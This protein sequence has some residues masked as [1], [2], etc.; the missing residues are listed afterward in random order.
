MQDTR[1]VSPLWLTAR[2]W[3]RKKGKDRTYSN[4]HFEYIMLSVM[5]HTIAVFAWML[6]I[7]N[8]VFMKYLSITGQSTLWLFT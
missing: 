4:D 5:F 2:V 7:V 6:R 3:L 1:L 8:P